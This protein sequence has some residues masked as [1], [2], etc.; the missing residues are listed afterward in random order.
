MTSTLA[1]EPVKAVLERL[2]AKASVEDAEA[3]R[4]VQA[5]EAQLSVRLPP[6]IQETFFD[7]RRALDESSRGTLPG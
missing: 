1:S 5:R 7:Q 2:H 4:R 3:K 6:R